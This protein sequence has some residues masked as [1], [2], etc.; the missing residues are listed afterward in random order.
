MV[1]IKLMPESGLPVISQPEWSDP[2]GDKAVRY[3]ELNSKIQQLRDLA[4]EADPII[5]I[6]ILEGVTTGRGFAAMNAE[7]DIPCSK[8]Y[9]YDKYRKF[10]YLLHLAK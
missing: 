10:F 8:D 7:Y 4:E 9:Y 1:E 3:A 2:T 5:G 6:Y